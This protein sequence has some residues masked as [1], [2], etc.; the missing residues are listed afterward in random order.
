MPIKTIQQA[1]FLFC[2]FV[3]AT[4]NASECA[5]GSKTTLE[6]SAI[7]TP[8]LL[9]HDHSMGKSRIVLRSQVTGNTLFSVDYEGRW[10]CLGFN[11]KSQKYSV[12]GVFERGA[13]LPLASIQYLGEDGS[14]FEQSAFDR[15]GYLAMSAQTDT[16]NRYIAFIGGENT[17]GSLFVLN[18]ENDTIKKLG[19]APAPPPQTAETI[20]ICKDEAFAWGSC[21]GESYVELD[22]DIIRFKAEDI[23]EVSYGLDSFH[24]RAK[25]RHVKRFKLIQSTIKSSKSRP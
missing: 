22:K 4:S 12:G 3:A 16:N 1:V 23:L 13:W 18:V 8:T 10:F 14:A 20:D 17:T 6:I 15:L 7:D 2:I 9:R 21:W 5:K 19:T 11:H 25:K 24:A